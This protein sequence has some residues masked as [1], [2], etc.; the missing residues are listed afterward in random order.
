MRIFITGGSGFIGKFVVDKFKG[1]ELLLLAHD[2]KISNRNGKVNF[3]LGNLENISAWKT[4]VK[5]FKPEMT[6]HIAWEG[7]PDYGI[8]TSLKNLYFGLELYKFLAEINCKTI[9]T[10]GSCWEYGGQN[11]KLSEEVLVKPFNAFTSAKNSLNFLGQEIAKDAN[12]NFIWTRLFY[13]YGPGQKEQSL[14]PYLIKCAKNNI[15]PEI[16][17]PNAENDFVYVEDVADAICKILFKSDKSSVYNIGSGKL[18]SVQ[19]IISI[20]FDEFGRSK[21]FIK[22]TA[23]QTDSLSYFYADLNKIKRE[24]GWKPMT[25]IKN[26]I[27]KTIAYSSSR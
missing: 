9:L 2:K 3:I 14:I 6:I 15:T 18:T 10:T 1:N 19:E 8:K 4:K 27:S 25:N 23:K 5:R 26:G 11:G 12:M 17:N 24:I 21:Q 13:I 22:K 16:K 20:I 7:I